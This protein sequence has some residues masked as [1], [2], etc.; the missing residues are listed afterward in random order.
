MKRIFAIAV[1][2]FFVCAACKNINSKN[3]KESV[4]DTVTSIEFESKHYDFGQ[5][6][7][8]EVV[9][10]TYVF[11]NTGK[12]DLYIQ[13][14]DPS[15]GCTTPEWPEGQAIK[16]GEKGKILVKFDTKGQSLG[17]KQKQ[18]AVYSNTVPSRN[19]LQFTAQVID[20]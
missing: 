8:G 1:A 14:V 13:E 12:I 18:V 3:T 16:P 5:I 6:T 20:E 4:K 11:K 7:R 17:N 15:C 19:L 9:Q 2:V 10:H